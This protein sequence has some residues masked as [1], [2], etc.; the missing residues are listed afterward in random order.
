MIKIV[1]K[2]QDHKLLDKLK[3]IQLLDDDFKKNQW[4]GYYQRIGE[5]KGY[6]T[7][8]VIIKS[9]T[10]EKNTSEREFN[11]LLIF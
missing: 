8:E 11:F 2:H 10:L 9:V 3:Q 5:E 6:W 1:E 4:F 7:L